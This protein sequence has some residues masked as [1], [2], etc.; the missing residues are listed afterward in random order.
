M[1]RDGPNATFKSQN[2]RFKAEYGYIHS[3]NGD[4]TI[5]FK[6]GVVVEVHT[7]DPGFKAWIDRISSFDL[8][9]YREF[10]NDYEGKDTEFDILDL[11]V[12]EN[13]V[14]YPPSQKFRQDIKL[15]GLGELHD[16]F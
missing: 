9:E 3:S 16:D 12:W 1:K 14:L 10:Y 13:N 7:D 6:T 5:D 4:I 2:K 8:D 11:G 15:D